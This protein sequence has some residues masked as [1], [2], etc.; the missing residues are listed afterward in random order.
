M[1]NISNSIMKKANNLP[2]GEVLSPK[3][4]LHLG[5]RA[6]VDQ[7][8][9]R[10][11]RQGKLFR[12]G[13]GLYA[14]PVE[15]LYGERPPAVEK[16]LGALAQKTGESIVPS[17]A[18]SANKLGLTT[19][20]PVQEVFLTSGKARNLNLGTRKVVLKRAPAWQTALGHRPAGL[21]VNALAW[22]GAEHAPKAMA[23]LRKSLPAE[24]RKVLGTL[25]AEFPAWLAGIVGRLVR[26]A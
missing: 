20:V 18:S 24:E 7:A 8:F 4:F 22:L 26:S 16:I 2:E 14:R 23:R 11:A 5:N 17:G 21:A 1:S 15:G 9:S 3:E 19:Q 10:L 6:A 13:W 12:V 25:C